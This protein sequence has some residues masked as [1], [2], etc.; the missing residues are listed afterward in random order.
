[1]QPQPAH[2]DTSVPTRTLTWGILGTGKIAGTFARQLPGSQTGKL[3]GVASRSLESA[4]R[5]SA[6]YGVPRAYSSYEALLA[7]PEI[8][9]VYISLPNHLHARWTVLC[10]EAG[11]HILC[12]KPLATNYAEAMTAVEAARAHG[13]FL[14]EAFMYRCHPQTAKLVELIRGGAIGDVRLI[15]A[16]FSYNMPDDFA[17]IRLQNQS[18]GGSIMDVGCYCMSMARLVAGAA[19]GQPF[20]N[21]VILSDGYRNDLEIKGFAHLGAESG[22]DEWATATVKF[23]GDIFANLVCGLHL[24]TESTVRIWGTAG[25]LVV[26]NPWFPGD[27]RF[28]GDAGAIIE[29]H[30]NGAEPEKMTVPGGRPL[31]AIEADTVAAGI[32]QQQTVPPAM[33]WADSLGNMRALDA[34]RQ[35]V[36]VVFEA[37]RSASLSLPTV[38]RPLARKPDAPMTYDQVPGVDKPVSRLVMGTM[39]FKAGELRLAA[40][41]LDYY[42]ELGGNTF[43]TAHVYRCEETVGEWIKLRGVREDLVVIG[44]GARDEAGT[45]EG[46]TAQLFETLQKMQLDYVDIY[47]LHSDNP[48]VPAGEFVEVLNEHKRAGR[49]RAFGGSN[50]SVERLMEANAYAQAHGLTGFTA[51]SP[52]L[53]LAEWNEPMWPK[54]LTASDADSRAWYTK[55][56][57]PLFA[58][59]SQAT[60][61]FTGRYRPEDRS[62][63]SYAPIVRTWFNEGNFQR[64]ARVREL[65]S[66]KGVTPSQIALAYVLCQPFPTFALIGPQSIDELRD[67]LPALEIQLTPEEMRWLNLEA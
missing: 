1:M 46:L 7:D 45:P 27:E 25:H 39:I 44:K 63:P 5:F 65:A 9:A 53:S 67:S 29:V 22:V 56:Q 11:K 38:G 14:M 66:R 3:L 17:N 32:D 28:G 62:V 18:A 4:A 6:E 35:Q 51:S 15:Q 42:Y 34:W 20:A 16:N 36:G 40:S 43:D 59:S 41:L 13:V 33:T 21:P 55:T 49:V 48:A 50:W 10:A 61:F 30:R 54:C 8:D 52:N 64:L 37:E 23:P 31:Y 12:E 24:R 60:G 47:L 19:L 58:W 57:M 2:P 26:P